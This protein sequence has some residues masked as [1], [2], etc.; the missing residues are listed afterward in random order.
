MQYTSPKKF[1]RRQ[2]RPN[3]VS[4]LLF[5]IPCLAQ[6]SGSA[7]VQAVRQLDQPAAVRAVSDLTASAAA[8]AGPELTVRTGP[9]GGQVGTRRSGGCS[10]W[11]CQLSRL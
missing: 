5:P 9:D 3:P 4:C 10:R 1:Y 11:T 8:A 6:R 2:A 7:A